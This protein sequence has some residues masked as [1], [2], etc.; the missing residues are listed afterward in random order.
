[1]LFYP[2]T[3]YYSAHQIYVCVYIFLTGTANEN[4]LQ[5]I[6]AEL[7]T[8]EDCAA[9]WGKNSILDSMICKSDGSSGSCSVSLL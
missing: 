1:M 3:P 5:E 7:R 9:A 4:I 6:R 8:N 2:V